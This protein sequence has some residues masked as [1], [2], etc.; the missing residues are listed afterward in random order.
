MRRIPRLSSEARRWTVALV[1]LAVAALGLWLMW[2]AGWGLLLF[3]MGITIVILLY[4]PDR[5]RST[6]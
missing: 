6:P 4:D 3:G 5:A 2:G 1:G